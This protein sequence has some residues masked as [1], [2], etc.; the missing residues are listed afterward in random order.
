M[1]VAQYDKQ[2][3]DRKALEMKMRYS[4]HLYRERN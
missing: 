1:H 2:K 3:L 4:N